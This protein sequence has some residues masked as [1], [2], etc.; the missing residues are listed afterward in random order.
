MADEFSLEAIVRFHAEGQR[1]TDN[2]IRQTQ[3]GL[4]E[5][6]KQGKISEDTFN[7]LATA[8]TNYGQALKKANQA[9]EV[10]KLVNSTSDATKAE[11]QFLDA[12]AAS[13]ARNENR[14]R[15]EDVKDRELQAKAIEQ[16]TV[17]QKKNAVAVGQSTAAQVKSNQTTRDATSDLPRLRYALYDVASTY[18]TVA[19]AAA[20][21]VTA[22]TAVSIA[23]ESAFSAVER[24]TLQA[25]GAVS[26][27]I[28]D[29]KDDLYD[30]ST[31]IPIAFT[32]LSR[33][34][35][36]GA[37]LGIA[38]TDLAKFTDTVAKFSATTN[39]SVEETALAFGRLGNLLD[40]SAQDYDRL[41]SA[42]ALAG[43]NSAATESEI[44]A[45][46]QNIAAVGASAGLS[47][48]EVVGL[49]TTFASLKTAPELARSVTQ[50]FF[51]QLNRAVVD[52]G[53]RLQNFAI[54]SGIAQEQIVQFA[55][56]GQSLKVLDGILKGLAGGSGPQTTAAL[57]ALGLSSLRTEQGI[58]RLRQNTDLLDQSL[59]D[60]AKGWDENQFLDQAF[61]KVLED[62]QSQL[63]L[64]TN[65]FSEFLAVAGEPMLE[66][67]KV[68][69]PGLVD[70]LKA[71]TEFA[72]SDFGQQF[73]KI[74]GAITAAIAIFF[75]YRAAVTLATASTAALITAN[76]LLAAQGKSAGIAGL[77]SLFFGVGTAANGATRGVLT[78]RGALLGLGRA[79]IIIGVLQLLIELLFNFE[80]VLR[81]TAPVIADFF[82]AVRPVTL[83]ISDFAGTLAGAQ[84][85]LAAFYQR[86]GAFGAVASNFLRAASVV[87]RGIGIVFGLADGN[88]IRNFQSFDKPARN[89]IRKS[90]EGAAA[91]YDFSEGLDAVGGSAGGAA[92]QVR[93]LVDYASDLLGVFTRSSDI[94]FKSQ[95]AVDDVADSWETLGDRI[96]DARIQLQSLTA[97][98]AIKE[99]FLG[100]AVNYGDDLRAAE[101]RAEIAELNAEIAD[102]QAEA[103]TELN[104]NSKAARRNRK[105][106]T[107]IVSGYQQYIAALAESGADQATLN[108]AVAASEQEFQA[109]ARQLGYSNAQI[110]PYIASLRDMTTI[111]NRVPR[112]ITV[113][114]NADAAIQALNEFAARAA[115]IGSAGGGGF[116]DAFNSA[117]RGIGNDLGD[118][119]DN[120]LR[121]KTIR[122][123]GGTGTLRF[124]SQGQLIEGNLGSMR[125]FSSGGYTGAG[126]KYEPAGIVHKGEYVVPKHQVDQRTGLPYASAL[127]QLQQ[128]TKAPRASYANG[129][130]VGGSGGMIVDLSATSLRQMNRPIQLVVDGKV[131]ASVVYG[132]SETQ[133]LRGSN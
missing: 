87:S 60:V 73:F 41:G 115:Q 31:T 28:G 35:S 6:A 50:Q 123:Q 33:I 17:A 46:A 118:Q 62:A 114:A 119:I 88:N 48:Q 64:L 10:K 106:L 93:T 120:A 2:A 16:A 66:F 122:I 43:V 59:S 72:K 112:N 4:D 34:A 108:A 76:Q 129:G 23:H 25:S 84:A 121:N 113:S 57:D 63:I 71:M 127:G 56:S 30:L 3:K 69:T 45:V 15:Q 37:Q 58:Q 44:I 110:Q 21:L 89:L 5:L 104:G 22:T 40:V 103:S 78:L 7:R 53:E 130:Y 75:A 95:L 9:S 132:N 117:A 102:T 91:A 20:G 128:G 67:I 1:E 107:G 98:L 105:E 29:I 133:A 94:R 24:T 18:R 85:S 101:L 109:Q 74:G 82:D 39:V 61:A 97:N 11:K 47:A 32:E 12:V 111:I 26:S 49:A 116:R 68:F 90:K 131:L 65:A 100:V 27:N 13:H 70:A 42:I 52:G 124:N 96:R 86:M 125:F 38:D 80:D 55:N 126:G 36:L 79:T 77:I 54:V 83:A 51:G 19:I 8:V 92:K 81:K 99:F 14:R